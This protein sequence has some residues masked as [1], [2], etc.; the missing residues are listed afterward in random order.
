MGRGGVFGF[1]A[2]LFGR[3][4]CMLG[5]HELHSYAENEN[6]KEPPPGHECRLEK[7]DDSS[8]IAAKF[9]SWTMLRCRRCSWTYSG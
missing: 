4:L 6:F 1:I 7:G 3:I 8:V 2:F 5:F 9:K